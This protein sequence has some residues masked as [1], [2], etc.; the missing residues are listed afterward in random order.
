F[1]GFNLAVK[2]DNIRVNELYQVVDGEVI[3]LSDGIDSFI[4]SWDEGGDTIIDT[5]SE[6][7]SLDGDFNGED[8]AYDGEIRDVTVGDDGV[9]VVTDENGTQH[10]YEQPVDPETGE[11]EDVRFTDSSGDTRIV[12]SDGNVT[13]SSQN[14]G[15]NTLDD[16]S[17][18]Q[19]TIEEKI[20]I[21]VL[22]D[23]KTRMEAWL[24]VHGKGPLSDY[25]MMWAEGLPG[26]LPENAGFVN[27]VYGYVDEL[28]NS[29]AKKK[30]F[31][32]KVQQ[33]NSFLSD[34]GQNISTDTEVSEIESV[35]GT[36]N[37][38]QAGDATCKQLLS[39]DDITSQ[40]VVMKLEDCPDCNLWKMPNGQMFYASRTDYAQ[41]AE[42][43]YL[44]DKLDVVY[45]ITSGGK[46]YL[47]NTYLEDYYNQD[48]EKFENNAGSWY[49]GMLLGLGDI[50]RDMLDPETYKQQAIGA[51]KMSF[52]IAM[53]E[54]MGA[55]LGIGLGPEDYK[56]L[57]VQM[58]EW[59][60]QGWSR[61]FIKITWGVVSSYAGSFLMNSSKL[62]L[63]KVK[64]YTE[65][66]IEIK[67]DQKG[68]R[69]FTKE[70][71]ELGE[72]M[73]DG[74]IKDKTTGRKYDPLDVRAERTIPSKQQ[75]PDS[76]P[77]GTVTKISELDDAATRRSLMRENESAG[78]LAQKGYDIEQN[79]RIE[80]SNKNPDYLIENK[81]FD[82][83]A[84][85]GSNPRNIVSNIEGKVKS[86]QTDRIVLN[87]DD[88][89][90]S[91]EDFRK[92]L[93]DYPIEGLLEIII[94]KNKDVTPFYPF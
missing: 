87:L 5:E 66:G 34:I 24:E 9:I 36:K 56:R 71:E 13:K 92:Q 7:D 94:I 64:K 39:E 90:L 53:G 49:D 46:Q 11:K 37:W 55:D 80:G 38:Q 47:W 93:T 18:Q 65:A 77:R 29:E 73:E 21:A 25:E 82:N 12:D 70:G 52:A 75:N 28:L 32:A 17:Q 42:G 45:S 6:S 51:V 20:V 72:V 78:V 84:P 68:A 14:N 10:T 22:E 27:K 1:L 15:N 76:K 8:I 48:G 23:F 86:G 44:F 85:S 62:R 89:S 3:A 88:S 57:Y 19:F 61:F 81:V 2:F 35:L 26:C 91:M 40:M 33:N 74:L 31:A 16:G 30:A 54:Q 63:F 83:Y 69:A 79:P 50:G 43:E 58:T 4:E 59:E 41:N 60:G 67:I